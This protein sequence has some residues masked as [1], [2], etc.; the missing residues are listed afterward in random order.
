MSNGFDLL[1]I[2]YHV[3]VHA[4]QCFNPKF[5]GSPNTSTF[6]R[7]MAPRGNAQM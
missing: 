3:E 1:F 4:S 5:V 7:Q 2:F 6:E